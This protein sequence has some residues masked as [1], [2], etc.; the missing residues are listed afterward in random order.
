M[1]LHFKDVFYSLLVI[2][3]SAITLHV[4]GIYLLHRSGKTRKCDGSQPL[5]LVNL[6]VIDIMQLVVAV[7]TDFLYYHK[8]FKTVRYL[9]YVNYGLYVIYVFYIISLTCNRFFEIYLNIHYDLYWNK[10][11]TKSLMAVI[12]FLGAVCSIA[13]IISHARN[14]K[15]PKN[16]VF[17][18]LTLDT[19]AVLISVIT[20]GYILATVITIQK[21]Q[22]TL[23]KRFCKN[24][25]N[26][27]PIKK[28]TFEKIERCILPSYKSRTINFLF[29]INAKFNST[30]YVAGTVPSFKYIYVCQLLALCSWIVSGCHVLYPSIPTCEKYTEA[31]YNA[32][33][34]KQ[35]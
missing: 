34:T 14:K 9:E 33:S 11:K 19:L 6:S 12:W 15:L 10:F 35:Y 23:T 29:L 13:L 16:F 17:L 25:L 24:H 28:K 8:K 20:N 31:L 22:R 1:E 3:C 26:T 4:S 32:P 18:S 2:Q 30:L 21:H 27:V 5:F 7:T